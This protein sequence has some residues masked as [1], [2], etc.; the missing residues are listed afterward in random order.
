[1]SLTMWESQREPQMLTVPSRWPH[2]GARPLIPRRA[3]IK[4]A[5]GY[6]YAVEMLRLRLRTEE[7]KSSIGSSLADTVLAFSKVMKP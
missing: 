2:G 4:R 7:L 3:R 6:G 5:S 1:M